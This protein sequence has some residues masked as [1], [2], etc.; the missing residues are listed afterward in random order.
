MRRNFFTIFFLLSISLLCTKLCCFS[1]HAF[2][3]F[4]SIRRFV[5]H[6]YC[7]RCG[8]CVVANVVLLQS[9]IALYFVRSRCFLA[10][11]MHFSLCVCLS[12]F[13]CFFPVAILITSTNHLLC[14]HRKI[15]VVD[16]LAN[17]Q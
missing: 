13:L 12:F 7:C 4:L 9:Y 2:L 8:R 1:T 11:F 3:R 10:D 17:L 5:E 14:V 6:V 16:V 15:I